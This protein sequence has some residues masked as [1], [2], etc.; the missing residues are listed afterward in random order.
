MRKEAKHVQHHKKG[1]KMQ[2]ASQEE[3]E[4]KSR[5]ERKK[6]TNNSRL[7]LLRLGVMLREGDKTDDWAPQFGPS[8]DTIHAWQSSNNR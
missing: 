2:S 6:Q 1:N 7:G 8:P 4:Q 3:L 5:E